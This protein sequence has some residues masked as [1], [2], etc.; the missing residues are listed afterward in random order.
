MIFSSFCDKILFS[1]QGNAIE[2]ALR[3]S[4]GTNFSPVPVG[5]PAGSASKMYA[6]IQLASL[7]HIAAAAECYS[8]AIAKNVSVD[9]LYNLISGAAG[10]SAQFNNIFPKMIQQD[11]SCTSPEGHDTISHA[12]ENLVCLPLSGT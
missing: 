5:G 6:V 2:T 11:F 10:S 1:A 12:M 7:I 9:L 8:L 3:G 4:I